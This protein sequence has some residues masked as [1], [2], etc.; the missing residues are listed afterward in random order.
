M[1]SCAF[2]F[3]DKQYFSGSL[4]VTLFYTYVHGSGILARA[5]SIFRLL[6]IV[7][8]PPKIKV[9]VDLSVLELLRLLNVY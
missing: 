2:C 8:L 9:F 5:Q 1:S 3:D 7:L 4:R 6:H